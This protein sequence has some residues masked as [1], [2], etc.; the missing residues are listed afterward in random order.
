[1]LA[2]LEPP[3]KCTICGAQTDYHRSHTRDGRWVIQSGPTY[4]FWS[5]QV[6]DPYQGFVRKRID[7][8]SAGCATEYA[9]HD[10]RRANAL[11]GF[12]SQPEL[13]A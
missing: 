6:W 12:S 13:G 1:M 3:G 5:E 2:A 10:Y 7:F 8:C 4:Y 9:A 11:N